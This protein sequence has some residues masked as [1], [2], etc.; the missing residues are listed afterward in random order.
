MVVTETLPTGP[1]SHILDELLS[2]TGGL[3]GIFL[4][5]LFGWPL[6]FL[7]L[8]P[9]L[10]GLWFRLRLF[11]FLLVLRLRFRF[12]FRFRFTLWWRG[13]VFTGLRRRVGF[14]FRLGLGLFGLLLVVFWLG[15]AALRS[16][17]SLPAPSLPLCAA[18][19]SAPASSPDGIS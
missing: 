7:F 13:G 18:P 16:L 19:P 4:L 12:R 5:L 9:F 8:R 2:S 10:L 11:R 6:R 14:W 1:V 17:S 3:L 15:F